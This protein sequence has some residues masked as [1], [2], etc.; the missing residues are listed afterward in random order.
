MLRARDIQDIMAGPMAFSYVWGE[1][2][3][4]VEAVSSGDV[5]AIQE[6]WSDVWCCGAV[7]IYGRTG[8]NIPA[9][10]AQPAF[11]KFRARLDVWQ[12][13]FSDAG[14]PFDRRALVEGGNYNKPH[15]VRRALELGRQYAGRGD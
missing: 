14:I 10:F 12:E 6:E 11:E 5:S 15:K 3:E 13:I 7:A 9:P 4:L 1:F 2:F 8:W